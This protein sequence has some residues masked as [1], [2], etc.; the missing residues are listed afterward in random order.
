MVCCIGTQEV[1]GLDSDTVIKIF[2]SITFKKVCAISY[3]IYFVTIFLPH[4]A[5]LT[6]PTHLAPSSSVSAT[7]PPVVSTVDLSNIPDD[8]TLSEYCML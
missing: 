7:Q 4:A 2:I 5:N 6:P 1:A 8:D 3:C